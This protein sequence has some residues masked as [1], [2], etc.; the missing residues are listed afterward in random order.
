VTPKVEQTKFVGAVVPERLHDRLK[1]VARERD[2]S[3]SYELRRAIEAYVEEHERSA[4]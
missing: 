2:R 1:K 4:A 3:V